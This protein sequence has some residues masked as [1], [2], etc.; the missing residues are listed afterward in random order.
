MPVIPAQTAASASGA[1][2][3]VFLLAI[4]VALFD[5]ALA[6]FST[7]FT[8]WLDKHHGV[9]ARQ[10][11]ERLVLLC[12]SGAIKFKIGVKYSLDDF[13]LLFRSE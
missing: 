8:Q 10:W 13:D 11:I 12:S 3:G 2:R 7:D 6:F 5:V 9:G 1:M 4:T